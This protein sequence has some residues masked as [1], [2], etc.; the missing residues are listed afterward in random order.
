MLYNIGIIPA[1]CMP[2]KSNTCNI[3]DSC[4]VACV[5]FPHPH[6]CNNGKVNGCQGICSYLS[7]GT[8]YTCSGHA[9]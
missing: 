7:H 6:S 5:N 2:C 4:V 3:G 8:R 9:R 1:W